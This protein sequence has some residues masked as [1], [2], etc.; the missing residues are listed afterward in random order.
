MGAGE[1]VLI[2]VG[3][4]PELLRKQRWTP[5]PAMLETIESGSAE[6]KVLALELE[7]DGG[8]NISDARSVWVRVEERDNTHLVGF[9]T[10]STLDRDGYRVGDRLQAPLDRI[11]DFVV[12]DDSGAARLNTERARFAVGKRI[13]V[14]V[15]RR[16]ANGDLIDQREYVGRLIYVDAVS[17]TTARVARW[18]PRMAT[19]GRPSPRGGTAGRIPPALDRGACRRP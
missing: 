2:G 10:R 4:L 9:I 8:A 6:V 15:T 12:F 13:L 17:R 3:S 11:F 18:Q 1:V 5:M 7:A 19:A 16:E 14:G